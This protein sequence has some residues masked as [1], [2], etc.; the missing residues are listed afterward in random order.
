[1]P[2][3]SSRDYGI[4]VHL[5]ARRGQRQNR[6]Q[7]QRFLDF[8]VPHEDVPGIAAFIFDRGRDKFRS[9]QDRPAPDREQEPYFLFPAYIPGSHEGG[10][11]RVGLDAGELDHFAPRQRRR[12]L[13]VNAVALD[14][15]AP[16]SHKDIGLLGEKPGK[17][18]YAPLAKGDFDRIM[19]DEVVHRFLLG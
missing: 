8:G 1:L 3:F 16:E 4:P 9:V 14:R 6:A 12:N 18:S 19:K 5:T 11:L 17:L 15:S 2:G 13:I 7:G 10:V